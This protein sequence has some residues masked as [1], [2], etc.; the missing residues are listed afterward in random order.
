MSDH[1]RI[2]ALM[3]KVAQ[4]DPNDSTRDE[5]L[6]MITRAAH[7]SIPDAHA[8]SISTRDNG[9]D[10]VT[11]APTD[12][13]LSLAGDKLQYALNE[14]PCVDAAG[15]EP[16]LRSGDLHH[17]DRWPQYGPRV[18]QELGAASQ[19]A[20]EMYS[21]HQTFGGLNL[22][23]RTGGAFADEETLDLAELFASQAAVVMGRAASVHDFNQAVRSR[24]I[25]GQAIGLVMERY[26]LDED[27]AFQFLVRMSSVANIKLRVVAEEIVAAAN[28]KV[29]DNKEA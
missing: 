22:Y 23:S 4:A 10:F 18:H 28:D 27:R 15:G 19:L 1:S 24:K 14:G 5:L 20:F 12:E 21:G 25:I 17:D 2:F 8:V 16:I 6:S 7:E 13:S 11:L 9:E 29:R 26:E 3:A